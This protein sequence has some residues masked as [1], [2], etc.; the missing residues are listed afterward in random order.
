V[1]VQHYVFSGKY[2]MKI[3]KYLSANKI[4]LDI[5]LENKEKLI[6]FLAQI[7]EKLGY[8]ASMD[9]VAERLRNREKT[10]STGIG[11]GVAIPHA[12][13][14]NIADPILVF[15]RP[16]SPLEFDALDNEPVDI[17]F[18]LIMPERK[19]H[20]HIRLLAGISRLCKNQAFAEAARTINDPVILLENIRALEKDMAFH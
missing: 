8:A 17:I 16:E 18:G 1:L 13:H 19:T 9:D 2:L 15:V 3:W 6:Q 10:M 4:F 7:P 14:P 12:V 11:N 5:A 20:L